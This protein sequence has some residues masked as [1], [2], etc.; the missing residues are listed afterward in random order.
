MNGWIEVFNN[1]VYVPILSAIIGGIVSLFIPRL[2]NWFNKIIRRIYAKEAETIDISGRWNSIFHEENVI[3]SEIVELKQEG[4]IVTGEMKLGERIYL[5]DGEFH[6]QILVGTYVSKNKRKFERG[7]IILRRINENLLSGFCTF[8]YRDK[9]VY[10]SPYVMT[11]LEYHNTKKGTYSF[12]N[13]CVGKFDCCCNCN[14]IDMPILLPE[15][16]KRIETS[17]RKPVR[18]FAKKMSNNL[19]QMKRVDDKEENGCVFFVN[20]KCVIYDE[21]PL[22]CRLFPFDFKEIDGEYWLIYYDDVNICRS[23]PSDIEE[24]KAYAHN[25][26]PLL[27]IILP[28]MS[29]CSMPIFSK[30]LE[31][32]SYKK[33]FTVKSLR[34]DGKE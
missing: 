17:S 25:I 7:T 22:D 31:N 11:S 3:Q 19:Y 23:L 15:E 32:Q 27:D 21:R 9:Q 29:E 33:L 1:Y 20:N 13:S 10:T 16:V 24:I 4:Q 26:R 2:F 30:R 6:N 5:L 18:E 8:V 28:Y 14:M 34:E 12:C